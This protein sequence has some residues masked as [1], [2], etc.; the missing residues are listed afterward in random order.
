VQ[1]FRAGLAYRKVKMK[2]GSWVNTK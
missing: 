2:D 1:L